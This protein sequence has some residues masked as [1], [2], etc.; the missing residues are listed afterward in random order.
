M[1][2][3]CYK[4]NDLCLSIFLLPHLQ[5]V[6]QLWAEL[7]SCWSLH[8][9]TEPTAS[10]TFNNPNFNQTRCFGYIFRGKYIITVNLSNWWKWKINILWISKCWPLCYRVLHIR[11]LYHLTFIID[12]EFL[13]LF[14]KSGNWYLDKYLSKCL[15]KITKFVSEQARTRIKNKNLPWD[16]ITKWENIYYRNY[17]PGWIGPFSQ[18]I[19]VK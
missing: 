3:L 7:I 14:Y 15:R 8:L 10:L 12:L 13:S 5:I 11:K 19:S 9:T 6:S 17:S 4:Y 18:K 1:F 16:K 2:G